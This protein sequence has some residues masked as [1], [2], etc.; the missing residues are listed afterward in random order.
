M[1]AAY[2]EARLAE[3][4][5]RDG[6]PHGSEDENSTQDLRGTASRGMLDI[7]QVHRSRNVAA[8]AQRRAAHS[9]HVPNLASADRRG[10]S[11][12][13]HGPARPC[14]LSCGAAYCV[15]PSLGKHQEICHRGTNVHGLAIAEMTLEPQGVADLFRY[16]HGH[17]GGVYAWTDRRSASRYPDRNAG[18]EEAML[19]PWHRGKAS[20]TLNA[21][22]DDGAVEDLAYASASAAP[23]QML[24]TRP[25]GQGEA[26][27]TAAQLRAAGP[28]SHLLLFLFLF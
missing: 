19:A 10:E 9:V 5:Y 11:A 26:A 12:R 24:D 22:L 18:Y 2:L 4:L 25:E 21:F 13:S 23:P 17:C 14:T 20:P 1:A 16:L 27:P 3:E 15:C 7:A 28:S 6:R 8:A